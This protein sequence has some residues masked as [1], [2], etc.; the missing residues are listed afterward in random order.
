[1]LF[2]SS[3]EALQAARPEALVE[4]RNAIVF[5]ETGLLADGRKWLTKTDGPTQ[6]DL[7]AVWPIHWLFTMPGSLPEDVAS[8]KLFPKTWA[9]VSR[10]MGVVDAARKKNGAIKKIKGDHA[11]ETIYAAQYAEEPIAML[12]N[13]PTGLKTGSEVLVHPIDSGMHNKDKGTLV[14]INW[15]EI[16]Y[17]VAG[18]SGKTVRVHTP[19]HG[20]RIVP[21]VEEAKI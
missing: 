8:E 9:W 4:L 7:E 13:E 18:E 21:N 12:A 5:L 6:V 14:S 2:R 16:V 20:F 1:M 15:E 10:F 19:R 3:K 17:D 11:A